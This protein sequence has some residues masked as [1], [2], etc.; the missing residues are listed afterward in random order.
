MSILVN[1]ETRLAV[2]GITGREGAFHAEQMIAYG[3]K[4][5][6][7]VTPGK[8]GGWA[9][10]DVPIFDTAARGGGS[11][12]RQHQHHLRAGTFCGRRHAR[13]RP[14]RTSP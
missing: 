14:T 7:G 11:H 3:T 2:Q 1:K 12:G 9:V 10:G 13:G 6:A 8:G 5:V 4:V